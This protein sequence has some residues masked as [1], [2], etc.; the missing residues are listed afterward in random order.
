MNPTVMNMSKTPG[1]T[2]R[3]S[4]WMPRSTGILVASSLA[5]SNLALGAAFQPVG[6]EYPGAGQLAGDQLA[7]SIAFDSSSGLAVWQ[8]HSLGN[9]WT[10]RARR[11][12]STGVG[13]FTPFT[14]PSAV[15][16]DQS[17]PQVAQAKGGNSLIVWRESSAG[18]WA[19]YGRA[20]KPG[21]SSPSFAG[22]NV[23]VSTVNGNLPSAPSIA[24]LE[25]GTFVVSW[26]SDQAD[27]DRFG[28]LAQHL[29]GNG[30]LLGTN[31]VATQ[32]FRANQRNPIVCPLPGSTYAIG[33]VS[34]N[35]RFDK[36][37]D[38][39]GR[40]FSATGNP[41][42]DEFRLNSGTNICSAPHLAGLP[43]GGFLAAWVERNQGDSTSL[44]SV[45]VRAFDSQGNSGT[46]ALTVVSDPSHHANSPKLAVAGNN[47]LL[48]W[49]FEGAAPMD[50]RP[51]GQFLT[52]SGTVDGESF[53]LSAVPLINESVATVTAL[54]SDQFVAA[55]T[56]FKNL[57]LGSEIFLR[58]FTRSTDGVSSF[59]QPIIATA[60]AVGGK[61]H[62]SWPTVSGGAYQISSSTNLKAWT[63]SG[64]E[65]IASGST[66]SLDVSP[67]STSRFFRVIRTR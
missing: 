4:S 30:E 61:V 51:Y 18:K 12:S 45:S 35:Q 49:H 28:I 6:S 50:V 13:L 8:D 33:W 43:N 24:A 58:R 32:T 60:V 20:L 11:L 27:G 65:R 19:V 41:M 67:D 59:P 34:E 3:R 42:T 10:I 14:V 31:F 2:R 55:W 5:I 17:Y 44:W 25:D 21:L 7:P 46:P 15:R 22:T 1:K 56:G 38:V 57:N 16:G 66:D 37:A 26:T 62:L 29:G 23:L 48:T 54:G 52:G 36:S 9:S 63:N 40:V 64:A 47:A 53:S 39:M